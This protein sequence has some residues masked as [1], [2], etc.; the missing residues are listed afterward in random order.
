[1]DKFRDISFL[2]YKNENFDLK[3][4]NTYFHAFI[5]YILR[6][7]K[8]PITMFKHFFINSYRVL[9]KIQT[10]IGVLFIVYNVVNVTLT[11]KKRS[12]R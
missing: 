3:N 6:S 12:V 8:Y 9:I 1:M 7:S 10:K 2:Y 11:S 4:I 5:F